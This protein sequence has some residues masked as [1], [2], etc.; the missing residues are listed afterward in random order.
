MNHRDAPDLL[1]VDAATHTP[2]LGRGLPIA[3]TQGQPT[4]PV[5]L[6]E[7]LW[8]DND[9]PNDLTVQ[10]WT[11]IAPIGP[12]GDALL[13][14]I[15]PLIKA[16][17]AEQ[18]TP[19][20]P[21]RVPPKM[22]AL[23]AA[24][25]K[26]QTFHASERHRR[27]LPRYQLILGDLDQ[28]SHDLQVCQA[29]DGFV[30][31]LAFDRRD[32]YAAYAA[33]LLAAERAPPSAARSAIFHSVLDGTTATEIGDQALVRPCLDLARDLRARDPALFPA[34]PLETGT[35]RPSPDALLAAARVRDPGVLLSLSHG[36]GAPRGGWPD[37]AA[38]RAG[39][40]A[41]SFAK[42]RLRGEDLAR[43]PFMPAGVW[44]MFACFGAGTPAAS[45]YTRWL[46]ALVAQGRLPGRIAGVD[47]SL[48]PP[49]AAPFVAAIPKAALANPNGPL[50]FIGHV[51]LAW[52]YSFQEVDLG[53]PLQQAGRFL[54]TLAAILRGDRV[55][56][57]FRELYRWFEQ[58][59][60]DL[61]FL[62]ESGQDQPVR[63]AQLW[64]LRQDLAGFTLLGDPAARI[65]APNLSPGT[66]PK[67]LSSGPA[68]LDPAAFF[69]GMTVLPSAAPAPRPRDVAR[70]EQAIGR[71][72][73]GVDT[74]DRA[75]ADVGLPRAELEAL[76]L[77]YRKA[78]RA[79][80]D[81]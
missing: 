78:G 44:F 20:K 12:D 40:G 57:A 6:T 72:L 2:A 74:L 51:D 73:A 39:Q 26:R 53:R 62:D 29:A 41:M 18:G 58:V 21:F 52:T 22:T 27:D 11:V 66:S 32:D 80:I 15:D 54:D 23:E 38:L 45:K 71:L 69:A 19:I 8:L 28:V 16:R 46:D 31:R 61:T 55:G 43:V 3:T 48:L 49:G 36:E 9:R 34:E 81:R 4:T 14:A 30:G 75:A 77:A 33:K 1:L 10:R 60:T 76:L 35:Y 24:R 42:D 67:N 64:L 59:N 47:D 50:A 7:H 79:A 70:L 56:V 65:P 63:R 13:A 68:D 37:I 25:W 5:P 17:A